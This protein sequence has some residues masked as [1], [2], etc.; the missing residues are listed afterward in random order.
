MP[1]TQSL[2]RRAKTAKVNNDPRSPVPAGAGAPRRVVT[3]LRILRRLVLGMTLPHRLHLGVLAGIGRIRPPLL[4]PL[5]LCRLSSRMPLPL[6]VVL[7]IG[8]PL[9]P[10]GNG[11]GTSLKQVLTVGLGTVGRQ[12]RH[13]GSHDARMYYVA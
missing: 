1:A 13:L 2:P 12:A 3:G 8:V 6:Q 9:S 7:G 10:S 5:R 4:P 11:D